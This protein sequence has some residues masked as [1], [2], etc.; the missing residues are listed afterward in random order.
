[1]ITLSIPTISCGHCVRAI[2]EAV[3]Q[4]DPGARVT[5]DIA[6]RTATVG[7]DAAPA[8]LCATLAAQGYPATVLAS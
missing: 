5:V 4:L 2:T 7:G 6:T 3:Q 1:M 8:A